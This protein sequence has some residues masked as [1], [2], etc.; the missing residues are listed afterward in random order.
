M[1]YTLLKPDCHCWWISNMQSDTLEEQYAV[2]VCFKLGKMP[3]KRMKF[4]R[5]LFDHLAWIDHQF[6][7][8]I[9]DSRKAGSPRGMMRGV[10]GVR[11][12]IYQSWL[13]KALALGLLCWGFKG[14]QEEIPSKGPA[15]V[16]SGQWHFYHNSI[17]VTDYLT[18]LANKTVPQPPFRPDLAPFDFLLFPKL[19]GCRYGTIEEMKEAVTK[20]IDTLTQEDF[21]WAFVKLLELYNKYIAAVGDHFEGDLSFM[22]VLS[23]KVPTR[24]KSGNFFND[25]RILLSGLVGPRVF[26]L[27]IKLPKI[28]LRKSK[29]N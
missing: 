14:V 17:L 16:K 11:T 26:Q 25:P 6:L 24:K 3:Q 7:S 21:D 2:K 15:L 22:Y 23:I 5:L 13:A 29:S 10:G 19:R 8:G 9:R 18:K 28:F 1:E 27:T 20:V 4:F 12:S